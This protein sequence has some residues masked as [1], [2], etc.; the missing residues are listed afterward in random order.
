[1][2]TVQFFT[3]EALEMCGIAGI[4]DRAG[5]PVSSETLVRMSSIIAHR[6]PDDEGHFVDGSV[7]LAN[8]RLAI[9]DLS[10][11]GHQPMQSASGNLVITYN[12]EIYNYR[13]LRADLKALGHRFRSDT[14]T[15][16][17]LN[18]FEEWGPSCVER[19]NGMFGLAI[20]DR[21]RRSLFLARDRYGIK[22]VYYAQLGSLFLF[23]SE[24]KSMLEHE[25]LS[26]RVS[27]PHLLEYFTFQNLFTEGTL[28]KDVAVLPAGHYVT[29]GEDSTSKTPKRD[30]PI[31]FIVSSTITL[32]TNRNLLFFI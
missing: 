16:V 4:F 30:F 5:A 21:Q 28:F 13:E 14:D 22:P 32:R 12:G 25:A 31:S 20:F 1:M 6:G 8:R 29:L 27:L 7:G 3:G 24:I 9:L 17:V 2:Y 18:A 26:A 10:S 11:A 15:E 23:G 19:F